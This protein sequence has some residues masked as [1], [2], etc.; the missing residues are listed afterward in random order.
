MN[1]DK[2]NVFCEC[3]MQIGICYCETTKIIDDE[4]NSKYIKDKTQ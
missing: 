2:K 4:E 1:E 3:F